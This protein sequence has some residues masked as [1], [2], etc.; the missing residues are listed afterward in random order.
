[1][2]SILTFSLSFEFFSFF[3]SGL[4]TNVNIAPLRRFSP[5]KIAFASKRVPDA[6]LLIDRTAIGGSKKCSF[7]SN[8]FSLLEASSLNGLIS[9]SI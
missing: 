3:E 6:C 7:W 5:E 4:N 8:K 1:M 2:T 9:S